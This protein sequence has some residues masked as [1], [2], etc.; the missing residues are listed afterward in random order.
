M[1]ADQ[2]TRRRKYRT[3][4]NAKNLK[5]MILRLSPEVRDLIELH[6]YDEKGRKLSQSKVVEDMIAFAAPRMI[7]TRNI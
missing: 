5:Q 4:C 6:S 2:K 1:R 7:K 3:G